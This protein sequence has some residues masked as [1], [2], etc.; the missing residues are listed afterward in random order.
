M[1][2]EF[3]HGVVLGIDLIIA[4]MK[5]QEHLNAFI[6]ANRSHPDLHMM[7]MDMDEI[8]NGIKRDTI[9]KLRKK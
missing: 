5:L 2:T 3:N 8:Y 1:K 4:F 7:L 6:D 9:R